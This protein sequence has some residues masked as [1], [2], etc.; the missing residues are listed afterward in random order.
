MIE[1]VH[2]R[3]TFDIRRQDAPTAVLPSLVSEVVRWIHSKEGPKVPSR[4]DWLLDSG[5][6]QKPDHRASFIVNSIRDPNDSEPHIWALRYSHVDADFRARRWTTDIGAVR[7]SSSSIRLALTVGHKLQSSFL[8]KEPG[9]LPVTSPRIIRTLTGSSN[10]TCSLGSINLSNQPRVV[11]V[12]QGHILRNLI[13][14]PQRYGAL[15]YVSLDRH[16]SAPLIDPLRLAS[17]IAGSGQVYLAASPELDDELEYL[18]PFEF[19]APNGMIRVYAPNVRLDSPNDKY[20]HRFFSRH[21]IQTLEAH[22]VEDQIARALTRRMGWSTLR[23][24]VNSVDDVL[25]RL[26]EIRRTELQTLS[27]SSSKDELLELYDSELQGLTTAKDDALSRLRDADSRVDEL[28]ARL[29]E[30]GEILGAAEFD[31]DRLRE[32][33][34]NTQ[35][36]LT[37]LKKAVDTARSMSKIPESVAD[38]LDVMSALFP[39][40]L[41]VTERARTSAASANLNDA[42]SGVA[43]A[44]R[45]LYSL[46]TKLPALAFSEVGS[47]GA[48]PQRFRDATGFQLS[49]TESAATKANSTLAAGRK[50]TLD[51]IDWDI[52][53]HLKFGTKSPKLLRVHFA[54]DHDNGR[55]IIGHCGD[56]LTTAGTR[57]HN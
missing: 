4:R 21:Q 40:V 55:L 42:P 6:W 11:D 28:E 9:R 31:R 50:L 57:R 35:K 17:A 7:L 29:E 15:V 10:W 5:E 56:H 16:T 27:D 36:E 19:R 49:L 26:R 13:A 20:R 32:S 3:C 53:P 1:T 24:S 48:L 44:W 30:K 34:V 37:R 43:T 33:V 38:V 46:A 8:G 51:G 2:F 22:E 47:Q 25:L 45:C 39:D 12:G 18:L 52:S 23:S 54:L 41:V 14:D